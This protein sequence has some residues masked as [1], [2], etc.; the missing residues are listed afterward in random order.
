MEKKIVHL[1]VIR[2]DEAAKCPF[3]LHIPDAC[4]IAG[5]IVDN[6]VAVYNDT[7]ISEEDA[8]TIVDANRRVLMFTNEKPAKCKYANYLFEEKVECNY[9]DTAAGLGNAELNSA[10]PL[11]MYLGV[12]YYSV[13]LGF[14]NQ[15]LTYSDG[16]Q[17][18]VNKFFSGAK[19]NDLK[20]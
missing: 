16:F 17:A 19:N 1:A 4:K 6:M 18:F 8:K 2:E 15:D 14:F 12:G 3:G 13:P 7:K 9:G 5:K 20:K 11:N 10:T